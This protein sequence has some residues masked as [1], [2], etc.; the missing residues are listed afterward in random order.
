MSWLGDM[1]K[2]FELSKTFTAA[3]FVSTLAM[4]FCPKFFPNVVDTVPSQWRWF[5]GGTCVFSGVLLTFWAIPPAGKWLANLPNKLR[6]NPL[7][8]TPTPQENIFLVFL[9]ENYP[10]DLLNLDLLKYNNISKL[11]V[12][13]MCATLH[14]KGLVHVNEYSDNLVSLTPAGRKYALKL[15]RN[16]A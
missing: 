2:H 12:L 13:D 14:R 1:L 4:L 3:I 6:D 7:I 15:M 9:G 10:N 5:V 11:E 16:K 8:N